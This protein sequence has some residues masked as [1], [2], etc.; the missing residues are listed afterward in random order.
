MNKPLTNALIVAMSLVSMTTFAQEIPHWENPDVIRVNTLPT[1]STFTH[2]ESTDFRKEQQD[3]KN[4]QLL[5]GQWKFNWAEKPEDRPKDFYQL[6]YDVSEW[7]E[8]DVPSDWQRRGYGTPI[9]TNIIYPHPKN[10]PYIP[11]EYNPVG[12]YK[13][14]FMLNDDWKGKN[15]FL[16]FAGVNSAFYV[17]VNG[18]QVGYAQ[19]SK[20]GIEFDVTEYVKTGANDIAVEVYRW[21]D[22][23]Y[24]EDQDFWRLSGIERDVYL[25]ATE[26]TFVRDIKLNPS[27]DKANYKD[28][29]LSYSIDVQNTSNKKQKG[30]KLRVSVKDEKGVIV[31]TN[32]KEVEL[33]KAESTTVAD[34]NIQMGK[35]AKWSAETP[36][37]YQ[38]EVA[39]LDKGG[40][41]LDASYQ[42]IGFRTTEIKNGQFLVN[43]QPVLL[44]GVNRHEH[45]PVHGHVVSRA[46]MLQDIIDLKKYNIN[47]VRTSHYPNDPYF[48]ELCDQYGI[49]VCNEANIESHGYGY[50]ADETLANNPLYKEQH[51]DRVQR[52]VKRDFNHPSVVYWSLGNE[53]GN[54]SNFKAAYDWTH[55]YDTSR[56]VHYERSDYKKSEPRTTDIISWMY[57]SME[58]VTNKYLKKNNQLPLDQQRPFIWCE[59]SHAMGNS[60]G[61]FKEYWD[62]VRKERTIQGGFIWDWQDQ[63]LEEKTAD[64]E[65]YYAYGGDYEPDSIHTDENFCANGI[66]GSD[67]T[68]HPA[69]QEIKHIYQN[70]HFI[71]VDGQN[72][73]LYNENFFKGLEHTTVQWELYENGTLADHGIVKNLNVKAQE[74]V[75]F[76]VDFSYQMEADKEYFINLYVINDGY[77]NLL[78]KGHLLSSNQFL[79]QSANTV[80]ASASK[81]KAK[82]QLKEVNDQLILEG[83]GFE[84]V[85]DLE[86]IGLASY[87]VN[88]EDLIKERPKLNFWRA[89][90]DNDFGAWSAKNP[91]DQYYFEWRDQ[92][93]KGKVIDRKIEKEKG[94]Y[95]I[96]YTIGLEA[97]NA[98]NTVIYKVQSNGDIQVESKLIADQPEAL[99][100]MPR[101]GV[102]FAIDKKYDTVNYYGRGPEENYIDRNNGSF[103]GLYTTKVADLYV[104]YTRPQENGHRTDVRFVKWMDAKE[105]GLEINAA[106][107]VEFNALF[108]PISDFDPGN[109]KAQRHTFDIQPRDLI[110]ICIDDQQAGVGGEN[111]WSKRGLAMKKYQ[112]DPSNCKFSFTLKALQED[113]TQ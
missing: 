75:D 102:T 80:S 28:G 10:A 70:Q 31:F 103:V 77:D 18:V 59:Y 1:H 82:I 113:K 101:Y 72:F 85:F 78:E 109:S 49:Y 6:A 25:F 94:C 16:H 3:L 55:A 27:L 2:Y 47:A 20:T 15:I 43:G 88:G 107:T 29:L 5:N 62:W 12:S 42:K 40:E 73:Q 44:K 50:K 14:D 57:M 4:Y 111:S 105:N 54:G 71:H 93:K 110:Y 45:D 86:E 35:V 90:T 9:Y 51:V 100:F 87:K 79:L 56:V 74:K 22:G 112:L 69:I 8:I 81:G 23:S 96:A 58:Q 83:N 41:V 95:R 104:P 34:Q 26:K 30:M 37:L 76:S 106:E 108:N 65:I 67:R 97:M 48:Y 61:N 32:T 17:W 19:G 11:H 84:V 53:A 21:C 99:K 68:P 7:K 36:H 24:L 46:M 98:K 92:A 39:L 38:L 63:G 66:I 91:K 33:D 60:N 64:G 89:M 52:M 13:R